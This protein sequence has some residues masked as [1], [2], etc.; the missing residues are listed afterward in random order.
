MFHAFIKF[1]D[2][3]F[4]FCFVEYVCSSRSWKVRGFPEGESRPHISP[5]TNKTSATSTKLKLTLNIHI[6]MLKILDFNLTLAWVKQLFFQIC[7]IKNFKPPTGHISQWK[8]SVIVIQHLKCTFKVTFNFFFKE[9]FVNQ[10]FLR[11]IFIS[12]SKSFNIIWD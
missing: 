5:Q 7:K 10:F 2:S 1:Y 9:L 8:Y 12:S 6:V 11:C 3:C 4:C